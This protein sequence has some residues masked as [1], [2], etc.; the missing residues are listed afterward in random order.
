MA[1]APDPFSD[2]DP[3]RIGPYS[4]APRWKAPTAVFTAKYPKL[5]STSPAN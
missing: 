4:Y 3:E 1:M 2:E 5:V